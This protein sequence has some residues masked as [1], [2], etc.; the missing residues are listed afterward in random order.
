MSTPRP[1]QALHTLR[2][3]YPTWAFLH[4]PFTHRWF[5]LHGRTI[6]L[7]AHTAKELD[8]RIITNYRTS[9]ATQTPDQRRTDPHN[10]R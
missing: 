9:S 10:P 4:D 8:T 6:T 7:T 5:A 2:Q 3:R 1:E